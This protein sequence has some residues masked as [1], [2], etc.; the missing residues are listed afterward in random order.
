M[1]IKVLVKLK[2]PTLTI[3]IMTFAFPIT[4][5]ILTVILTVLFNNNKKVEST[6]EDETKLINYISMGSR[7]V[8]KRFIKSAAYCTLLLVTFLIIASFFLFSL[9]FFIVGRSIFFI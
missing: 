4:C 3:E 7:E 9:N 5:L 6:T 1:N 8:I 2:E